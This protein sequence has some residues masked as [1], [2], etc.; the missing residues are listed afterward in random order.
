MF[1]EG[2]HSNAIKEPFLGSL[3]NPLVNSSKNKNKY[4]CEELIHNLKNHFPLQ[5]TFCEIERLHGC[6]GN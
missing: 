6:Y 2:F 4:S 3:M 1:Q 5:R